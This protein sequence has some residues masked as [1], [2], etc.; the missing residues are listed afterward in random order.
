MLEFTG[1][2]L[3]QVK[4]GMPVSFTFRVKYYDEKRDVTA[5]YWKAI[6]VEEV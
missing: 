6:P 5:Y 2:D 3:E 4:V 1:C